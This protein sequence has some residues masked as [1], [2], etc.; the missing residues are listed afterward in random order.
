MTNTPM[1]DN[2]NLLIKEGCCSD[3]CRSNSG[4]VGFLYVQ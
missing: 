4:I 2:D 3:T 1:S